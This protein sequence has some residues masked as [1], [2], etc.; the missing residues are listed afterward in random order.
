VPPAAREVTFRRDGQLAEMVPVLTLFPSSF[1][2][3]PIAFDTLAFTPIQRE[4]IRL[5]Y[6]HQNQRVTITMSATPGRRPA[7]YGVRAPLMEQ[8]IALDEGKRRR[9]VGR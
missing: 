8:A 9:R 1:R 7:G 3:F 4:H 2:R 5:Q 6:R